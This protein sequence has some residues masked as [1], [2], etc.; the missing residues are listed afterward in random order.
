[1][2]PASSQQQYMEVIVPKNAKPGSTFNVKTPDKQ[3]MQ[4]TVPPNVKPKQKLLMAYEPV[5][6]AGAVASSSSAG[7]TSST[8]NKNVAAKSKA[9]AKA[10]NPKAKNFASGGRS[11]ANSRS[12]G[13]SKSTSRNPST[14]TKG[15]SSKYLLMMDLVLPCE[16]LLSCDIVSIL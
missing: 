12:R 8:A 1:M 15:E 2:A 5:S 9:K 3:W 11:A 6:K 16:S 10:A 14:D 4:V 13:T 7:S